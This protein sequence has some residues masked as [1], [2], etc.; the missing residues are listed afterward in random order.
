MIF[1]SSAC[2]RKRTIG[3]AVRELANRGFR[4]I[5]LSGGTAYYESYKAD[6]LELKEQ[7]GLR[8]LLHNY[9]PPPQVDF[10]LN[11]A[12]LDDDIFS[13]SMAHLMKAMDLSLELKASRFGF[14]AGLLIAPEVHELGKSIPYRKLADRSQATQRFCEGLRSLTGSGKPV[15]LYLEN[16]VFSESN[17]KNYH[18]KN[19][20]LLTDSEGFTELR[21]SVDCRLLLDVGHLKVSARTLHLPFG[22][23][24]ARMI[25]HT[26]YIHLSENDGLHDLNWGLSAEG[27]VY[28]ELERQ[29]LRGKTI[30]LEIYEGL[31]K[32]EQSYRL[33]QGLVD[34][35]GTGIPLLIPLDERE[36][37]SR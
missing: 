10:V 23:Q 14:H 22:E 21:R 7:Y 34:R 3:E 29:D 28:R 31:E 26:D 9:F 20:F 18:G 33:I 13:R 25:S 35:Q 8:Y 32:L 4:N 16:H 37:A 15:D 24:L 1:V 19:P 27:E 30:T 17:S 5:E 12:S 2:S 11:L 6:L 36:E